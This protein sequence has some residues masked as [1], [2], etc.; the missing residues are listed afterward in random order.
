MAQWGPRR[1]LF[2]D[3]NLQKNSVRDGWYVVFAGS[4]AV[5]KVHF[6]VA[7][8]RHSLAA[9]ETACPRTIFCLIIPLSFCRNLIGT[10]VKLYIHKDSF[11]MTSNVFITLSSRISKFL[12]SLGEKKDQYY[13]A[14][15]Q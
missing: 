3:A 12:A 5:Q 1:C 10:K 13:L 9:S 4:G 6:E 7:A 8:R 14:N 2:N 11:R 15:F